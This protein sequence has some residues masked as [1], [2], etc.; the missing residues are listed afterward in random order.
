MSATIFSAEIAKD[1]IRLSNLP[2]VCRNLYCRFQSKMLNLVRLDG[3]CY[4]YTSRIPDDRKPFDV[5]YGGGSCK[6]CQR[7]ENFEL[8]W[9]NK[10]KL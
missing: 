7:A 2:R 3:S 10:D 1:T 6:D 5:V 4:D 8:T 9:S